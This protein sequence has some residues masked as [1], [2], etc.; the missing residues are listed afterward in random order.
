[1]STENYTLR[2]YRNDSKIKLSVCA[3]D[4]GHA[5]AQAIDITRSLAGDRFEL[6][7]GE[8]EE[9]LLAELYRRLA[10]SD[11]SSKECFDWHGSITNGVPAVYAL[12]RRYYVRPLIQSYLD[13]DRDRIVK[14]TCSCTECINPYHNNYLSAKNSKLSCGDLQMA[15][16]FRSQG[17]SVKQIAKALKVHRTTIY[18][19]LKNA[20]HASRSENQRDSD[21]SRGRRT[22]S[23]R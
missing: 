13:M 23:A 15:L 18:K 3:N 21:G 1:V 14:N 10:Y 20:H 2:V 22:P 5:Q 19:S 8:I 11:F 12:G 9:S 7:Y 4:H 17:V 16:A 6:L